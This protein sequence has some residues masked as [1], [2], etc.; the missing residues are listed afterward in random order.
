ML[1]APECK[2]FITQNGATRNTIKKN[3]TINKKLFSKLTVKSFLHFFFED[4]Q[5]QKR[6]KKTFIKLKKFKKKLCKKR[7]AKKINTKLF[8]M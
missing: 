6:S 3:S 8:F 1:L 7:T 4:R 2:L 5:Q